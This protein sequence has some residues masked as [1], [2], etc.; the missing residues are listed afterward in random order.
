MF[1]KKSFLIIGGIVIALLAGHILTS[2][3]SKPFFQFPGNPTVYNS[4]GYAFQSP[5]E[6]LAAGGQWED[7]IT[8]GEPSF[9]GVNIANEYHA[10]TTIKNSTNVD[11]LISTGSGTL[12]SVIITT[13]GNTS[14][15]LFDATTTDVT[16]RATTQSTS[17]IMIASFPAS[18]T[19]G[20]Y[21]FD[22]V[23]TK[24]LFFD[25]TAGTLGTTTITFR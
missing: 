5:E 25:V 4:S 6:F 13:A 18:A 8:I 21:T 22:T 19:V 2:Q 3:A 11:T 7:I 24:G 17:T 14:F 23:F 9:G 10:T 15:D 20:T 12:G 1:K 16:K